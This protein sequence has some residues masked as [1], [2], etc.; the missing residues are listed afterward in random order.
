[1]LT[2]VMIGLAAITRPLMLG[3]APLFVLWLLFRS[4]RSRTGLVPALILAGAIIVTIAPVT[5]R[6]LLAADD[7]VIVSSSGG[8]NFYIGNNTEADGLSAAMPPPLGS[9]WQIAEIR[10]MAEE[11]MGSRLKSS[12]VSAYW[13]KRGLDWIFNDP[14]G[15]IRLYIKKMYFLF[16]KAEIS[17]NRNID[18]FFQRHRILDIIPLN[19]AIV[20]V[21]ALT[22]IVMNLFDRRWGEAS[23]FILSFTVLYALIIALF[24]IN[25]RFRLP[26]LPYLFIF[27]SDGIHRIIE[28]SSKRTIFRRQNLVAV[29]AGFL[30][31][32]LSISNLYHI[33][34]NDTSGGM[35][36]K[37]NYFLHLDRLN[38][39]VA[40]YRDVLAANPTYPEA[41]L[42]LGA[43]FFRMARGDSAEVYFTEELR[44]HPHNARAHS[45]MA[46]LYFS[47]GDLEKS[48]RYAGEA[49]DR[50]PYLSDPYRILIR[51]Q[52][53]L[54]DT[55][56]VAQTVRRAAQNARN[57][58]AIDIE[59]GI[60]Y[61]QWG[62]YDRA[63]ERLKTALAGDP[64]PAETDDGAFGYGIDGEE[65][66]GSLK[67]RA[68]YQ[69]GYIYG[70]LG[71]LEQS[72]D[73]SSLAIDLDS[74]LV[75]AYI[76][77]I[78]GYTL[79]GDRLLAIE[80]LEEATFRFPDN[81]IL[82]RFHQ[83]KK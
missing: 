33:K 32:L 50:A 21:L 37:A 56:G 79:S 8:I 42:N 48:R 68:A 16:N 49:I 39:A 41:N 58:M 14:V 67:A 80:V 20:F 18:H 83:E 5:L 51:I 59:A 78:N 43:A 19:F 27:A 7:F 66:T 72:I 65:S 17:N 13:F 38:E 73:M 1:L 62:M 71:K 69:L 25:A 31:L 28:R 4:D 47:R 64:I 22:G 77:L 76:N 26:I 74:S 82:Q 30:A 55:A 45:N 46:S 52:A 81:E 29:L 10:L 12:E 34:L 57:K 75:E 54:D 23:G 24:F 44:H 9:S 11:D 15:F 3:L 40:L 70:R 2:G 53:T 35:F 36:N 61:S 60:V 6:N 63:I